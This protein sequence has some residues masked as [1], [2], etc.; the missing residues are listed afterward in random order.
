MIVSISLTRAITGCSIFVASN[1]WGQLQTSCSRFKW[2]GAIIAAC[3]DLV[4][5]HVVAV[6]VAIKRL[7]CVQ[8][9]LQGLKLSDA[10]R[11]VISARLHP[12]ATILIKIIHCMAV[13]LCKQSFQLAQRILTPLKL[14]VIR[15]IYSG[16]ALLMVYALDLRKLHLQRV[17]TAAAG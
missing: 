6:L 2:L 15:L 3:E 16:A 5:V 11:V 9:N 8:S 12:Y 4:V 13:L 17:H 10:A 14:A 7:H 1:S